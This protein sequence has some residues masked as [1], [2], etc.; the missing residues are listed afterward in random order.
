VPI[1][2]EPTSLERLVKLSR[3]NYGVEVEQP[4]DY[5]LVEGGV[6]EIGNKMRERGMGTGSLLRDSFST[7]LLK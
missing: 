6:R 3:S 5:L 4:C 7:K 2:V 1:L